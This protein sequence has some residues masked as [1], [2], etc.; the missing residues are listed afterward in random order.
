MAVYKPEAQIRTHTSP[1]REVTACLFPL[2]VSTEPMAIE[3]KHCFSRLDM[4]VADD[5]RGMERN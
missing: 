2:E 3:Q 5:G 4:K 1:H